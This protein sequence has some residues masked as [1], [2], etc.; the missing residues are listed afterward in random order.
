MALT[1][2]TFVFSGDKAANPDTPDAAD[3]CVPGEFPEDRYPV[4]PQGA[5]Y[6]GVTNAS[7]ENDGDMPEAPL[8]T[9]AVAVARLGLGNTLVIQDGTYNES[10]NVTV[11]GTGGDPI[12]IMAA[13]NGGAIID[14]PGQSPSCSVAASQNVELIGLRCLSSDTDSTTANLNVIAASKNVRLRWITATG[15]GADAPTI[16]IDN[17]D[18]VVMEDVAALG[19]NRTQLQIGNSKNVVVRRFFAVSDHSGD[20]DYMLKSFDCERCSFQNVVL[21]GTRNS[22]S[23]GVLLQST[24]TEGASA[25]DTHLEASVIYDL[26]NYGVV[27]KGTTK[28]LSRNKL[29]HLVIA[30]SG[31]DRTKDGVFLR[32]GADLLIDQVTLV[33][34]ASENIHV[35]EEPDNIPTISMRLHNSLIVGG[36]NAISQSVT[37]SVDSIMSSYNNI[38]VESDPYTGAVAVTEEANV[39]IDPA[40]PTATYGFGA[41][42]M[43]PEILQGVGDAGENIGAQVLYRYNDNGRSTV[44]LWPWPMEDRIQAELGGYRVTDYDSTDAKSGIWASLEDVYPPGCP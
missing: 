20:P 4:V 5:L 39:M 15:A 16:R 14:T 29:S 10:L 38:F 26:P 12:R 34:L 32:G 18:D 11:V 31:N 41:Y 6:V 2:C 25:D 24:G 37:D 17:S 27:T 7:D 22:T 40:F 36:Q 30:D 21:R 13:T 28:A 44:P 42:L 3:D 23:Y 35:G 8:A 43:Q 33:N 1:G 9:F 19:S